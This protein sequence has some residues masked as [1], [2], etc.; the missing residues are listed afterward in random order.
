MTTRELMQACQDKLRV[1]VREPGKSAWRGEF[2]SAIVH[3]PS[4]VKKGAWEP[5]GIV[6]YKGETPYEVSAAFIHIDDNQH[7]DGYIQA[8]AFRDELRKKTEKAE[9]L[10]LEERSE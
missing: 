8:M 2:V 6:M 3:K 9:Q 5:Y 1:I 4:P 7:S 10:K